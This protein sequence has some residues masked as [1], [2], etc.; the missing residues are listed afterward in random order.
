MR[1]AVVFFVVLAGCA[2]SAVPTAEDVIGEWEKADNL[3]PPINLV[4]SE[5][6]G[7]ILARL[8][9][10]GIEANG[11]ATLA[12]S[13][14][15]LTLPDRQDAFGEFISKSELKLR[16]NAAGPDFLLRKRE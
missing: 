15:R 1:W 13:R 10:S 6:G 11:T 14:L 2:T 3:L 16:L 5:R 9:L 4:L 12:D 8:R 7:V